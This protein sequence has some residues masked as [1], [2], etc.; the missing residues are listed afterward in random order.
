MYPSADMLMS[1]Q[2][3][4]LQYGNFRKFEIIYNDE[5]NKFCLG[6]L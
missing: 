3:Y 5:V 1:V 6:T 4:K 2:K